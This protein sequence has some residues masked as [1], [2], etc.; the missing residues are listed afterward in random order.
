MYAVV[1]GKIHDHPKVSVASSRFWKKYGAHPWL[2][3]PDQLDVVDVGDAADVLHGLGWVV[4][5]GFVECV[6][7][8]WRVD[9]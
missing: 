3:N 4:C 1:Y 2:E 7:L 9:S 5:V 8:G 6:G